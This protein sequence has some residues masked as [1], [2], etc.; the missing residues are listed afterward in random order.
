MYTAMLK[1]NGC[2]FKGT[3]DMFVIKSTQ[4]ILKKQEMDYTVPI[5]IN[6]IAQLDSECLIPFIIT[7][8]S[9]LDKSIESKVYESYLTNE[10]NIEAKLENVKNIMSYIHD[11]F[12]SCMPKDNSKKE[13]IYDDE[14]E[15]LLMD[16]WDFPNMEYMWKTTIGRDESFWDITPQNFFEQIDI[17]REVNNMT[18]EA[19][20]EI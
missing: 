9:R 2:D 16:D 10:T 5:L 6:K 15:V 13:S 3:I 17:F 7:S 14:E 1:L 20:E 18:N 11:L 8:I 12:E 19:I 4:Q